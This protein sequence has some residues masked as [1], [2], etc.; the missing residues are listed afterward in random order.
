MARKKLEELNLL[1]NFL[2]GSLVTHPELG[3][4][5]IRELLQIIFGR[6]FVKLIVVPQKVYYGTGTDMHGVRLDV[7]LETC[8]LSI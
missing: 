5:F 1:D 3:K 6:Q 7:Y 4:R 2:F 8:N